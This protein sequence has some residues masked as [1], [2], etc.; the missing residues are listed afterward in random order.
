MVLAP[1]AR[2]V[3]APAHP[4]PV[5]VADVVDEAGEDGLLGVSLHHRRG[6]ADVSNGGKVEL[7]GHGVGVSGAWGRDDVY[8]GVQPMMPPARASPVCMAA[9][10]GWNA[11]TGLAYAPGPIRLASKAAAISARV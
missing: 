10:P 5:V 8:V 3:D 9:G 11:S 2:D 7:S 6:S 4:H 1:V